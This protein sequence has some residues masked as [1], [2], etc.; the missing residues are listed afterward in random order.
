[1]SPRYTM[2][3][4]AFEIGYYDEPETCSLTKLPDHGHSL[5]IMLA[6]RK[7]GCAL[8]MG[9]LSGGP[10]RTSGSRGSRSG[11]SRQSRQSRTGSVSWIGLWLASQTRL[12]VLY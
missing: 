11:Q 2:T 4:H 5:L 9:A 6:L 7:L 10:H 8:R 1:M 3:H 12:S